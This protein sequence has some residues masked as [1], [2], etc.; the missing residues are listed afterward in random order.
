MRRRREDIVVG[1]CEKE[2]RRERAYRDLRKVVDLYNISTREVLFERKCIHQG[3]IWLAS[4][5]N[6]T[7]VRRCDSHRRPGLK[8]NALGGPKQY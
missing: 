7:M 4:T 1:D 8:Y 2:I 3:R 5:G 6:V